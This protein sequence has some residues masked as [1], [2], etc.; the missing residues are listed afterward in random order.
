MAR[1]AR[2]EI[3]AVDEIAIVHVMNRNA[4]ERP[5]GEV[6]SCQCSVASVQC[7]VFSVLCSEKAGDINPCAG[8]RP[9][10]SSGYIEYPLILGC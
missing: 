4:G 9:E 2:V 3:F 6:F 7:S 10:A 5:A 8:T 1:L